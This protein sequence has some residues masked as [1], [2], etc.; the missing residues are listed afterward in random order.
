MMADGAG[1]PVVSV[2]VLTY[3][4]A[5]TALRAVES[6]TVISGADCE[7]IVSDDGSTDGTREL[8]ESYDKDNPGRIRLLPRHDN[9]GLTDNYF[10]ALSHCRGRYITDLAGDDLRISPESITRFASILDARPEAVAVSTRWVSGGAI[11][12]CVETDVDRREMMVR[13]LSFAKPQPMMLS[14]MIYRKPVIDEAILRERTMVWN[15]R[16]GCEDLPLMMALLSAG[17]IIYRPEVTVEYSPA[18]DSITANHDAGRQA[19]YAAGL[20]RASTALAQRYGLER[21]PRISQGLEKMCGYM[22]ACA[23]ASGDWGVASDALTVCDETGAKARG[24]ALMYKKMLR[25]RWW[26]RSIAWLKALWD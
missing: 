5:A 25:S 17:Q 2:I 13:L 8:L 18:N 15:D 6:V 20:C 7:V 3:N 19:R 22:L 23:A 26:L 10:Y 16:F 11:C 14:A 4:Q 21:E 1:N 9:M 12:G 24:K